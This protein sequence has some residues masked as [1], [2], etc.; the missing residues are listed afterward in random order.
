MRQKEEVKV[1][2]VEDNASDVALIKRLLSRSTR[3]EFT[4]KHT[5]YTSTACTLLANPQGKQFSLVLLDMNVN[6]TRGLATVMA[7]AKPFP[8]IPII[9]LSGHEDI[10]TADNAISLGADSFIVKKSPSDMYGKERPS[11]QERA[12]IIKQLAEELERN[13]LGVL[14][15]AKREEVRAELQRTALQAHG[16]GDADPATVQVFK[17]FVMHVDEVFE[18]IRAYLNLNS[19]ST[20][21]ALSTLF[22]DR[23]EPQMASARSALRI[24]EL[25]TRPTQHVKNS[26]LR[27]L[28]VLT[29][30]PESR[31]ETPVPS[32][33]LAEAESNLLAAL[34]ISPSVIFGDEA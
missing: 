15:R 7:V 10:D 1:L 30:R 5:D 11:E 18:D 28:G 21:E 25:G 9:V 13:I 12:R 20:A 4:I 22:R 29:L 6:D 3:F 26:T 32:Q 27:S 8:D 34:N 14:R 17:S 31:E 23:V 24:E 2:L 19:P 33:T 16:V